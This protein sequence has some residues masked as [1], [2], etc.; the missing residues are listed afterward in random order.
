MTPLSVSMSADIAV[1]MS[2]YV[3][4]S[5]C[6]HTLL[7]FNVCL[8]C[9]VSM[10]ASACSSSSF[11]SS[12]F[13]AA[14]LSQVSFSSSPFPTFSSPAASA[15]A[16][17][18]TAAT[19]SS[20]LPSSIVQTGTLVAASHSPPPPTS[21]LANIPV[22]RTSLGLSNRFAGLVV[23]ASASRTEDQ[24]FCSF[25]RRGDFFPGRFTP[26]TYKL[27]LHWLPC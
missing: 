1:P 27:A 16:A 20:N 9:S 19:Y 4:Q 5:Q 17:A 3:T 25:L 24:G 11:S 7:S 10:S 8:Y 22:D 14:P 12:C 13:S 26:V 15:V 23:K 21:S 2:A 6:L 18:E